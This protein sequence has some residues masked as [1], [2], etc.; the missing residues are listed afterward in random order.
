VELLPVRTVAFIAAFP[1]GI[2]PEVL[3]WPNLYINL[4]Q[5]DD[6]SKLLIIFLADIQ[7]S[8]HYAGDHVG[9]LQKIVSFRI[10]HFDF[11]NVAA[12]K[13]IY[14]FSQIRSQLVFK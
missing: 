3:F 12:V 6:I 9:Q 14:S 11:M 10:L 13:R 7:A 2:E 8:I 5:L 1:Q 4:A